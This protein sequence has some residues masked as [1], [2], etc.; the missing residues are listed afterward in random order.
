MALERTLHTFKMHAAEEPVV[1]F[2]MMQMKAVPVDAYQIDF[3]SL[4]YRKDLS[5]SKGSELY[6]CKLDYAPRQISF[7][8]KQA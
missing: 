7:L 3:E 6:L 8:H 4:F 1:Y 5:G 2:S